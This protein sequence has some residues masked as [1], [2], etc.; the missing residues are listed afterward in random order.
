MSSVL[1]TLHLRCLKCI[2][3]EKSNV[4]VDTPDSAANRHLGIRYTEV[5]T[6]GMTR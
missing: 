3:I 1:N 2:S 4:Q 5:V 6:E